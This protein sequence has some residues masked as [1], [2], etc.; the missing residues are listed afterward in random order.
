M[1]RTHI[2]SCGL[3]CMSKIRRRWSCH[4]C[5]V[6]LWCYLTVYPS[7]YLFRYFDCFTMVYH[8][9]CCV[10]HCKSISSTRHALPNPDKD[11]NRFKKWIL[12][13]NNLEL[14]EMDPKEV[15]GSRRLC[16]SHF[17]AKYISA[18]TRKLFGN[19]VPTLNLPG[20][21][22]PNDVYGT[23]ST[24]KS[25]NSTAQESTQ[26]NELVIEIPELNESSHSIEGNEY[27]HIDIC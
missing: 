24:S 3:L 26:F 11:I 14:M 16:D 21:T 20:S 2:Y 23:P 15:Y 13:I 22:G 6:G 5:V 25:S 19:A 27:K 4:S 9:K 10:P 18:W 17:E 1:S 12:V 7:D 8:N